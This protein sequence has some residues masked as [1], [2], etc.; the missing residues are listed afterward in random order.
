MTLRCR[1]IASVLPGQ[2][3]ALPIMPGVEDVPDVL[4]LPFRFVVESL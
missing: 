2:E 1:V 4:E 3:S